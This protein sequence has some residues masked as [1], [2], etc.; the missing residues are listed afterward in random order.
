[1][2]NATLDKRAFPRKPMHGRGEMG[3]AISGGKWAIDLLDVSAGGI[4]FLSAA[5]SP[6][7]STWL[8]RF[9][10]KGRT[11]RG[12]VRI[13]YCVK[14]SLADAYRLGAAFKDLEDQYLGV[15]HRYLNET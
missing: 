15:I 1:M 7:D 5:A 12:V 2:E 8:I 3:D 6:K 9:E 11:V 4:S 14:H 10:L 13:V